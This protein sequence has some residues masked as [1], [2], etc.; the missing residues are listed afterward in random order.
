MD[1]SKSN[2]DLISVVIPIRP[3]SQTIRHTLNSLI[4]QDYQNFEVI[5]LLDRDDGSIRNLIESEF[6]KINRKL[7]DVDVA[8]A[9]LGNVRN[10]GLKNSDSNYIAML[11]CDDICKSNRFTEQISILKDNDEVGIVTGNASVFGIDGTLLYKIIPPTNSSEI[12]M[13]L[14]KENCIVQSSVMLRK[15]AVL[16]IG[17]YSSNSLGCEDYDLWLR[18]IS[19]F[20]FA[21]LNFDVVDYLMNPVG[22]TR[23]QIP[24]ESRKQLNRSRREAQKYLKIGT[25]KSKYQIL[26]WNIRQFLSKR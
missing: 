21:N 11:D 8:S 13:K 23:K 18:M 26:N 2:S 24:R 25:V 9:G 22:V 5:C 12:K 14:L 3:K 6:P 20:E 1:L 17:G 19:K 10:I 16:S 15:S 4:R 7:I